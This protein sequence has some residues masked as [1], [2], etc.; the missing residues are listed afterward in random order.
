MFLFVNTKSGGQRG[1][2]FM[3]VPTPFEVQVGEHVG[4]S[5]Q[6]FDMLEGAPGQKPGF[7]LLKEATSRSVVRM[8]VAG[9]DGTILW[10]I[11]EAEKHGIDTRQ[12]VLLAVVPLGTGNDF[13]R[14]SG[15]GGHAPNMRAVTKGSCL[16]LVELVRAWAAAKPHAHDIWKV[17]VEVEDGSRGSIM[18]TGKERKKEA[19]PEKKLVKLMHSYFSAGNDARAGM[20]QEK[21]RTSTR[22]GNMLNYGFQICLKGMPFR[23]KEYVRDFAS[24]LH[25]GADGSGGV[26]FSTEE[27]EEGVPRLVGN[28]QV[29]LVLNIP[30]CY[31]GFC[32]FW[33]RAISMGVEPTCDMNLLKTDLDPADGKLEVLTYGSLLLEPVV[34]VSTGKNSLMNRFNAKRVFSGAPLH[35]K[36]VEDDEDDVDVHVQIDGEF[37]KLRNPTSV[38][39][40]LHRKIRVLYGGVSFEPTGLVDDSPRGEDEASGTEESSSEGSS[41]EESS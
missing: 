4:V 2:K 20:G 30:N 9:G 18:Q 29:L 13:A 10:A 32:R 24:S 5:L 27:D 26:V 37:F 33:E 19:I 35:M 25:H 15:W 1:A 28:P 21:A 40:E 23:E 38:S 3:R 14:F 8:I 31:G 36:F 12:Q 6:I 22:W 11:E 34:S 17:S 16:G 39:F 7:K 41:A